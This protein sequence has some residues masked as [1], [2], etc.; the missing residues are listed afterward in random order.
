[1]APSGVVNLADTV[2]PEGSEPSD[3]DVELA[4]NVTS[5]SMSTIVAA[6]SIT[7]NPATV[8]VTAQV[9][10]GSAIRSSNTLIVMPVSVPDTSPAA[11]LTLAVSMVMSAA[12]ADSAPAVV[13]ERGTAIA[14]P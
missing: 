7:V 12:S 13:T 10:T 1:M 2:I 5:E 14:L 3:N 9:S 6:A 11:M 8:D 4:V